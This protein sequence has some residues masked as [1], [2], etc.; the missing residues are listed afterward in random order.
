MV[1]RSIVRCASR[2]FLKEVGFGWRCM[3]VCEGGGSIENDRYNLTLHIV[4]KIALR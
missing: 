3:C 2:E 1:K 4:S